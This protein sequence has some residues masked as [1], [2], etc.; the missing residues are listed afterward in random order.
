MNISINDLA[1]SFS[2]GKNKVCALIDLN[3]EIQSGELF[4]LIGPSGCGKTT[5]IN[6]LAGFIPWDRGT[7][8]VDG[9]P[10]NGPAASRAVVFQDDAVF[11]WMTVS[12][13]IGY[14]LK[15]RGLNRPQVK[16]LTHHFIHLVGLDGCEN[17]WPKELSGG[18]KKRV[19]LA[20][21]YARDPDLLLMD[22]PFGNLDAIT[23]SRMQEVLIDLWEAERKTIL[24]VTH[25]LEEALFL[26]QRVGVLTPSPGKT[27]TIVPVPFAQSRSTS[28]RR[29]SD[30]Q[31]LRWELAETLAGD[32]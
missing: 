24:F 32:A 30:F 4:S 21:T 5:L 28:I 6:I 1:K 14:A 26:G 2:A 12:Q 18:M 11:P 22:E 19:E 10:V 23:R 9:V 8:M 13:N 7:V 15:L 16:A 25:D 20:R 27:K 31:R 17:K 3:L 29:S